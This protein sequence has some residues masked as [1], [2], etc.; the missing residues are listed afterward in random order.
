MAEL[1]LEPYAVVQR[2]RLPGAD[3]N[4][5]SILGQYLQSIAQRCSSTEKHVIGHIKALSIFSDESY[6]RVSVV[7]VNIP[8]NIDGKA[9][10]GCTDLELTLN[11]LVYGLERTA[12]EQITWEAANEIASQWKGGV[13]QKEIYQTGK[14][15][16][17]SNHQKGEHNE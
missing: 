14:H 9:P 4:W 6:L 5:E 3:G 15:P 13:K 7:A 2:W 8:A 11:V 12:V 1:T 16:Y 10:S 17:H